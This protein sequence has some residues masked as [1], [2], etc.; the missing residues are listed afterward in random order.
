MLQNGNNH[1]HNNK[2]VIVVLIRSCVNQA[3]KPI[4]VHKKQPKKLT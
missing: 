4:Y 2:N 1:H 3:W